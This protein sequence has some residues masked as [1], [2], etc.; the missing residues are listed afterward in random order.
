[1][2]P[3]SE[4]ISLEQVKQVLT[5]WAHNRS[6]YPGWL[7]FPSGQE[8]SELRWRTDEWE[9]TI[10]NAL[11]DFSPTERLFAVHELIWRR[12]LLLEP[13]SP[14]LEDAAQE[15]LG[16]IDCV[17]RKVECF[18]SAGVDWAAVREAWRS[19]SLALVT[20]ARIDFNIPLFDQR[21][22]ALL[23]FSSD[24]PD[25]ANYIEQE[26][27]LWSAYSLDFEGLDGLLGQLVS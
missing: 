8:R 1:M 5:I 16:E 18:D 27:C 10:L 7:V 25:V 12:E 2:C 17:K 24:S 21:L 3:L 14:E 23:P 11:E 26:R 15:A 6:L 22:E 4:R 9:P 19:V 20:V 13:I